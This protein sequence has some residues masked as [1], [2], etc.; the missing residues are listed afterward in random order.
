M[1][2]E[3]LRKAVS[4]LTLASQYGRHGYRRI[5]ALLWNAGWTVN[6]KPVEGATHAPTV[7]GL[8]RNQEML[9]W[10]VSPTKLKA[11]QKQPRKG[12]L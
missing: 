5:T 1:V 7:A 3:R 11:P 10:G 6:V 2:R 12:R 8:R 4:D 9:Q